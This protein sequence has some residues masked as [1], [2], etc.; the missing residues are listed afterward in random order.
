MPRD[1]ASTRADS[2]AKI[3]QTHRSIR[4]DS[5]SIDDLER[6]LT[7]HRFEAPG[8]KAAAPEAEVHVVLATPNTIVTIGGIEVGDN[9]TSRCLALWSRPL[10]G[11]PSIDTRSGAPLERPRMFATSHR[12][13]CSSSAFRVAIDVLKIERHIGFVGIARRPNGVEETF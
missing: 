2:P 12:S 9:T 13:A 7:E 3:N 6:H 1:R 10:A 5:Q 4:S 8:N 11:H